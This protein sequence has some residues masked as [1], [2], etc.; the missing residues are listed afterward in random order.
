MSFKKG[1]NF[2]TLQIPQCHFL[3]RPFNGEF[4]IEANINHLR[5]SLALLLFLRNQSRDNKTFLEV[6]LEERVF[7]GDED[8]V[9][10]LGLIEETERLD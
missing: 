3:Q 10:L 4:I 1:D 6:E 2:F 7:G 8:M 5:S 9:G